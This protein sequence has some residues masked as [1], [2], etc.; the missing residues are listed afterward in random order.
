VTDPL[1][2]FASPVGEWFRAALGAPTPV[3]ARG[4][5]A[6]AEGRSALLLAPTGSGK[7]LA[8]F[9][10][11]LNRLMFEP[12]PQRGERLLYV[13]PLKALGVDVERNLRA[14]IAG[15]RAAA[16]RSGAPLAL[17]SVMHRSGDTPARERA[18]FKKTPSDAQIPMPAFAFVMTGCGRISSGYAAVSK[19]ILMHRRANRARCRRFAA[20]IGTDG[21]ERNATRGVSG[22]RRHQCQRASLGHCLDGHGVDF[23]LGFVGDLRHV[24]SLARRQC[25]SV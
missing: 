16:E 11:A 10:A 22:R 4:W 19:N 9:Q 1:A 3:Q 6:L 14:P 21:D 25:E 15:I 18:Q 5:E 17:P 23:C 24:S 7:T 8:A 12:A 2:R 20:T 13:S